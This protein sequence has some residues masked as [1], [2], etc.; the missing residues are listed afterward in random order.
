MIDFRHVKVYGEYI[1]ADA[2]DV[3][4]DRT[5]K[6]KV[7]KTKEEFS[8]EPSDYDMDVLKGV[9]ALQGKLKREKKLARNVSIVWY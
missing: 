6:I 7:H 5:F 9:W 2:F 3:M 1:H 8:I 4:R